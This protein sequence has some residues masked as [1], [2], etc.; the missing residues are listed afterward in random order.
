MAAMDPERYEVAPLSDRQGRPLESRG[1]SC[2]SPA[3]IPISTSC[4]PS[5][6]APSAKTAP[7]RALFELADLPYVGANVLASAVSM[8]KDVMKRVCR[9]RGLPVVD[10]VVL[11]RD[12]IDAEAVA[13]EL[14][15][16]RCS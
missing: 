6:T 7:C 3:R 15:V 11:D 13:R 5:C 4:F 14:A 8:D 10:Y 1:P 16:S 12:E 9:E 2:R